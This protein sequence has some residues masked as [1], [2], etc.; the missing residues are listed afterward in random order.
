MY[1]GELYAAVRRSVYVEGLSERAAARH[2]GLARETV[3]K[4]LRYRRPPGY[5]RAQPIRR[6]KLDAFTGI[7]DQILREDQSRPKKQR[8]TA[9]RIGERLRAEYGFTG[10][11]TIVNT[12]VRERRLGGQEMFVPLAHPPGDAQADFGE[13]L[14]VIAGVECKAHYLVVDLPHSDDGFVKAFPA[15]TTEAFCDGHNAAFCYFGGVPRRIVYDNTKLAVARILGDG[16]RQRTQVFS[17]LQS[18]YLFDDRFGRPG[19]GNDKGKV[20]GLVG[21]ARRNFFVPI[22]RFDS[23]DALNA[24]LACQCRARRRRRLR[25]HTETIGERFARDRAALLPLPPVPYDARETRPTRV[26]SLAL[27]RYRRNDYSV[28]TAYGH[29][30]VL[31]KGS[32][33]DVVIVCGSDEIARHRRSYGR[34]E[35]IFDP[36]HYLALLERK[37]GALDQAAPLAGWALPE[38]F[39]RL[40]R[41]LEARLGKP[42][43]REY[44]QVLRLLEDFRLDHV[45]G[46]VQD[47][48]RLGAIGFDAVKHTQTRQRFRL[49]RATR[50][51]VPVDTL[52]SRHR[53]ETWPAGPTV[54][55]EPSSGDTPG[56]P[57]RSPHAKARSF[58]RRAPFTKPFRCSLDSFQNHQSRVRAQHDLD[59]GSNRSLLSR[60]RNRTRFRRSSRPR[61]DA[62]PAP[63]S[64]GNLGMLMGHRMR[65]FRLRSWLFARCL[66]QHAVDQIKC[67]EL[68]RGDRRL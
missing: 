23:W 65:S 62:R 44:V 39:L 13:A 26:T 29:R 51:R 12:Y 53:T 11:D 10:G 56:T 28:P 48:V 5:R 60:D 15:E 66:R 8:H 54:R 2:F 42:G 18:H 35:L 50:D 40:R 63:A 21:H 37:T 22:P 46:A 27:V 64:R 68:Q 58:A 47:A 14:V 67:R 7:I 33:D 55:W 25:R 6:P 19:K 49:A 24:D 45:R 61:S 38:E 3:R 36:R 30:E 43:T 20:E 4:M 57:P 32:V 31:V 52:G 9:K 59:S 1:R 41:L 17:E 16:T 34:E